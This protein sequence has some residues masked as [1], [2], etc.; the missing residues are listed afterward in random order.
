MGRSMASLHETFVV[1]GSV[2]ELDGV[3]DT[4]WTVL[5]G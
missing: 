4:N 3:Q 2:E 1:E 5:A